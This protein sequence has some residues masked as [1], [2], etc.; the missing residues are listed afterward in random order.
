[1]ISSLV[2]LLSG[3]SAKFRRDDNV[4]DR[5]HSRYTVS[6]LVLFAVISTT[7]QLVGEPITCWTPA[8]FQSGWIKYVNALCWVKNTYFLPFENEIP[9]GDEKVNEIAYYQWV[10]F[11]FLGMAILFYLPSLVWT[12]FNS[13]AGVD[14]DN[15]LASAETFRKTDKVE[16]K[17][18]L[19]KCIT[20]QLDR[21]VGRSPKMLAGMV[22]DTES[23]ITRQLRC[24]C[25]QK[26]G[27][28]LVILYICTKFLYVANALGQL[29]IIN[30]V[31][32][33][34]FSIYGIQALL[35]GSDETAFLNHTIF[36]KV[37]MCD[38]TIR[39]TGNAQDHTVQCLLSINLYTEKMFLFI[40]FWITILLVI[41]IIDIIVWILR[42]AVVQD[43]Y[44]FVFNS[45]LMSRQ[46]DRHSQD[47]K[48]TCKRFVHDYL[49][50][51]GVFVLRLI[52]HNTNKITASEIITSLWENWREIHDVNRA[53]NS[54]ETTLDADFS[55]DTLPNK[56]GML[57]SPSMSE[58][59][60]IATKPQCN[61]PGVAPPQPPPQPPS[62]FVY[63]A[64]PSHG[65]AYGQLSSPPP[66]APPND[67][68]TNNHTDHN[69]W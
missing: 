60:R 23:P 6:F 7:Y 44:N 33:T 66:S 48:A 3:V 58:K 18:K 19:L 9:K 4:I 34:D 17:D 15:I 21:F 59:P 54:M 16:S 55:V 5:F 31:M 61:R 41:T 38:F 65:G 43:R 46:V 52:A 40:W 11:I 14:S 64:L 12:S 47:D 56:P 53:V 63:P 49:R 24:L 39:T 32:Q 51:D 35:Y 37:T 29:F 8:E 67:Y 69:L 2:T 28:Y 36:P 13:K 42:S 27:N 10:P 30:F 45:L 68:T 20:N 50:L 62:Q 22:L 26:F 25:G 1:M 57:D